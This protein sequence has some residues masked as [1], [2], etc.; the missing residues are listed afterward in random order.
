VPGASGGGCWSQC[1]HRSGRLRRDAAGM[2][3]L[4]QPAARASLHH[5]C[6]PAPAMQRPSR[7]AAAG[8]G[9][10]QPPLP[11]QLADTVRRPPP[12]QPRPC[13]PL[14]PSPSVSPPPASPCTSTPP[15][16]SL[17]LRQVTWA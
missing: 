11:R 7:S 3:R 17:T 6:A 9:A 8:Q 15:T 14:C 5:G 13:S 2:R 1:G 12:L 10:R 4:A 16:C